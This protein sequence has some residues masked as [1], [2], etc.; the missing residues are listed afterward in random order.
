[1]RHIYFTSNST[2]LPNI[3]NNNYKVYSL[4][5]AKIYLHKTDNS[6]KTLILSI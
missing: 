6:I 2:K 3:A 4:G 5:G 1:M